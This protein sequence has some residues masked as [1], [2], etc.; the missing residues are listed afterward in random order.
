MTVLDQNMDVRS[1][2]DAY[3]ARSFERVSQNFAEHAEIANVATG[4]VYHG[5]EGYLQFARGWVAAFPDLRI[6]ILHYHSTDSWAV[7]EYAFR[8]TH[9]GAM[10]S[11]GGFV[12]PT[13]SQ[14]DFRLCDS[15]QI[16]D[17][18][19]VRLQ[20]F[21]DSATLLRQMGLFPNS[22][23]HTA[24]RRA[25]LELY[26][27]EVDGASQQRNKAIVHRF[28]EQVLNQHNV[29]AAASICSPDL[30]WH[31]GP[32]GEEHNLSRFQDRLRSIFRSFPDLTVEVHDIIAEGDRVAVR[33]TMRGTQLGEFSGMPPTGRRI[34]SSAMNSYR[35][36]DN[37]IVEEWWQHD[38]LGLMTQLDAAPAS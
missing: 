4:D 12:P 19:I 20:T 14:V 32:M 31:G 16:S 9:T 1:I 26:A 17:G 7:V 34:V 18:R 27:T 3:Q 6:E 10:I 33:L 28:L 21:F 23:L 15:V 38:L 13:W 29:A 2:Y 25:P 37:R 30:S 22:P 5:R 35:I 36:N 24:D 8:G 11:N